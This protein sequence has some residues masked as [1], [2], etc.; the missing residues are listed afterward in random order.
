MR[1]TLDGPHVA[2]LVRYREIRI[3]IAVRASQGL[4]LELLHY[5]DTYAPPT[6]SAR[7]PRSTFTFAS[8]ST[9]STQLAHELTAAPVLRAPARCRF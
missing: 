4:E 5:L 7:R 1:R 8:W 6:A 2:M 9:T 3:E